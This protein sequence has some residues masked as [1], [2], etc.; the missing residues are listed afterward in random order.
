MPLRSAVVVEAVDELYRKRRHFRLSREM[1][2]RSM[3]PPG[4][5]G[6]LTIL[7]HQVT[8]L[9]R[10]LLDL[11]RRCVRDRQTVVVI[12]LVDVALQNWRWNDDR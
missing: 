4:R 6:V 5:S 10:H 7:D 11:Q 8:R 9:I 3:N 2:K 1:R 12:V